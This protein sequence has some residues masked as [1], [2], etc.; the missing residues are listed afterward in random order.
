MLVRLSL[1]PQPLL[2][3]PLPTQVAPNHTLSPECEP[4]PS[5][6]ECGLKKQVIG[7]LRSK[8]VSAAAP[9]LF[10]GMWACLNL[11][12]GGLGG[13]E[14][15]GGTQEVGSLSS[16]SAKMGYN[17][18]CG[19]FLFIPF[20]NSNPT[21]PLLQWWPSNSEM[22]GLINKMAG[23]W[24]NWQKEGRNDAEEDQDNRAK[25]WRWIVFGSLVT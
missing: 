17:I 11:P 12:N 3:S 7:L 8:D 9:P 22:H 16:A 20:P 18:C 15:W 24:M 19:I 25:W 5:I 13:G 1:I 10:E 6:E 23:K 2:P 14:T 4:L 21:A